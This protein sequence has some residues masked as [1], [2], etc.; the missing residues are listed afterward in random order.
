MLIY[1]LAISTY[2]RIEYLNECIN[3]W[4]IT[5][6]NDVVWKILIAD[7]GSDDGTLEY[8]SQLEVENCE[9]TI[10]KNNRIGVHQQMNTILSHLEHTEFDFCFKIDDDISFL[11]PGWDHLYHDAAVNTGTD[12][13]VFCDKNWSKE[14]FLDNPITE[15]DKNLIGRVPMMHAHGFFYTIT[16]QIIEKVGFMDVSSFGFRGMGHVD[17]TL[18][19]AKAGFT[20]QTTPWDVSDSNSYISA[21]KQNYQSVIPNSATSVYDSFYRERKEK[22]IL[23][24]NRIYVKNQEIDADLYSKFKNELVIALSNKVLYFESEKKELIAWYDAEIKKVSTWHLSQY[25]HLP[26]WYLKLGKIF[27]L[28]R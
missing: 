22:I 15:K 6:S 4:N 27:K 9:I 13:L 5:K 21:T 8:L 3:S 12:H 28:K 11:K 20:S 18:R 25:N 24:K 17:F 16:P 7:D 23:Q 14:Q 19:C 10:L 1:I 2:N 26:L